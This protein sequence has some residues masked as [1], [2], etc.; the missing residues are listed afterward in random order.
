M[1]LTRTMKVLFVATVLTVGSSFSPRQSWAAAA[2][3]A[4]DLKSLWYYYPV[5]ILGCLYY[6]IVGT[7]KVLIQANAMAR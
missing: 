7:V 4:E 1:K 3:P 6:G 5:Y 2:A